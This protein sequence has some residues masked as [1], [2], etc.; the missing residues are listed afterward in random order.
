VL[1]LLSI[2]AG[3]LIA[4]S[5]EGD[6]RATPSPSSSPTATE[7]PTPTA[8]PTQSPEPSEG[9]ESRSSRTDGTSCG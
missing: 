5:D 6:E 9:E 3:V 1:A 2:G 8:E 4:A 7:D